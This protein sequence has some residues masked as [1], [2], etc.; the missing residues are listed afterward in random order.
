MLTIPTAETNSSSATCSAV[1][2]RRSAGR[3]WFALAAVWAATVVAGLGT[4][5]NH[6]AQPGAQAAPP[7]I[8]PAESGLTRSAGRPTLVMF[9]HPKCPCTRAS[10]HELERLLAQAAG[11]LDAQVAF[12]QPPGTSQDWAKTDTWSAASAIPSVRVVLDRDGVEAGRFGATTS[13]QVLL[14][15]AAGCLN[16]QG[17]IT[18]ARGHEGDNPGRSA[19]IAWTKG[20]T[21]PRCQ[22]TFGCPLCSS[23]ALA[24]SN[25]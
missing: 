25:R 17:G 9:A 2:R 21:A 19:I 15:D 7:M 18:A 24:T 1:I 23:P 6:A 5:W 20:Q 22:S 10:L 14:Y 12:V 3:T 16:F 4:L 8:W 11:T 13:G